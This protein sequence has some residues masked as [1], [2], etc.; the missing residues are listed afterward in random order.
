MGPL[1]FLNFIS[2]SLALAAY[3]PAG[4]ATPWSFREELDPVNQTK[5]CTAIGE[6]TFNK[7]KVFL[8]FV[9]PKDAKLLPY[10]SLQTKLAATSVQAKMG[11]TPLASFFLLKPQAS[12][13]SN[14]LFWYAPTAFSK[15][16]NFVR[17][18]NSLDLIV[19]PKASPTTI[20]LSLSGSANALDRVKKCLGSIAVPTD[21]FTLLNQQKDALVPDLGDRSPALLWTSVNDAYIS[22]LEGKKIKAA[23]AEARKPVAPL[24]EK[25]KTAQKTFLASTQK[26]DKA[27]KAWDGK[28]SVVQKLEETIATGKQQL[29]QFQTSKPQA[30][31]DLAQKKATYEPLKARMAPYEQSVSSAA[32]AVSTLKKSI[33][34]NESLIVDNQKKIRSMESERAS[35]QGRIPSLESD[36]DTAERRKRDAEREY[37]N[38]DVNREAR[39][40][41]DRD[42]SYRRAKDELDRKKSAQW[43]IQNAWLRAVKRE[44]RAESA[45]RTCKQK[46]ENNCSA[47]ESELRSASDEKNR[48]EREY[49]QISSEISSLERDV[50][51][52]E[53]E[54]QRRAQSEKDRLKDI[55]DRYA[56]DLR[57]AEYELS[58]A[59]ER[60]VE[61]RRTIPNLQAQIERAQNALPAQRQQLVAAEEKLQQ[62]VSARDAFSQEI[63]FGA[64]LAAFEEAKKTLQG[65]VTGMAQLQKS[66]P[67]K[68]KELVVAKKELATLTKSLEAARL[69]AGKAQTALATIQNQLAVFREKEKALADTLASQEALFKEKRA[70]Y[71]DLWKHLVAGN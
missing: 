64:A 23:L 27:Q 48:T 53:S 38:Y 22:F 1:L 63:G 30:E 13:E 34:S 3:A 55:Y 39:E 14:H 58:E 71:Q 33:A 67:L 7:E 24:L 28:T 45:L 17:A 61:I 57:D 2:T 15:F 44:D 43:P 29:A 31:T 26:L 4:L 37:D 51:R 54:A 40:T 52:S 19:N 69:E 25:E 62:A 12:A 42:W 60:I 5:S 56:R 10:I 70:L 47:E 32:A 50:E 8:S 49:N 46:P 36:V 68:E 18:Q 11:A 35:L 66:I 21:F 65:I 16:E 6:I 41:L 59:R 9:Y 20:K